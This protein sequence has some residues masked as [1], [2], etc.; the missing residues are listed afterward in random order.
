MKKIMVFTTDLYMGGVANSTSKIVKSLSEKYDVSLVVY[1]KLPVNY[2]V[3]EVDVSF[4]GFPLVAEYGEYKKLRKILRLVCLP[5]AMIKFAVVVFKYKPDVI[6]SLMYVPNFLNVLLSNI[7]GYRTI[8]SE[9]QNPYLD[10]K[11]RKA[12]VKVFKY[13]FPKADMV[14]A[15]SL[16]IKKE[17]A[18]FY[19]IKER[20]IQHVYNFFSDEQIRLKSRQSVDTSPTDIVWVGRIGRQK[21][22]K[23]LLNIAA[24]MKHLRPEVTFSVVGDGLEKGDMEALIQS[25]ELDN[26]RILGHLPNPYPQMASCKVLLMTSEWESFGN[27]IVEAMALELGVVAFNCDYG[28]SEILDEGK[29]GELIDI[30]HLSENFNSAA[31]GDFLSG[32]MDKITMVLDNAEEYQA[33]SKERFEA[34]SEKIIRKQLISMFEE[35]LND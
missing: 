16:G 3:G 25:Y 22:W 24:E 1:E 19:K 18:E 32:A 20:K 9:R 34:F 8:I 30:S 7:F 13:L 10:L 27:V 29:Y 5:L 12:E 31:Y 21:G 4:L 26:I 6:Y 2:D 14:H 15:N 23:H 35:A 28:P 33:R 11:D 17:V